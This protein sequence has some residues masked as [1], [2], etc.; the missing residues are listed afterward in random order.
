M[1]RNVVLDIVSTISV[2]VQYSLSLKISDIGML[3][4]YVWFPGDGTPQQACRQ[5]VQHYQHV[6]ELRGQRVAAVGPPV[7]A[8]H[9]VHL[10]V[11]EVAG[12]KHDQISQNY[13]QLNY[14]FLVT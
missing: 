11:T 13:C 3:V 2:T 4:T 1:F 14:I 9:D 10:V 5:R 12:L 8:P 6:T 7:L